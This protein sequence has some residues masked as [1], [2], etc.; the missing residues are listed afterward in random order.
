MT[1]LFAGSGSDPEFQAVKSN[2]RFA[3]VRSECE[4]LWSIFHPLADSN[5]VDQFSRDFRA[6]FWELYIGSFLKER[7]QAVKAA[8]SGS[9]APDFMVPGT[10]AIFVEATNASRGSGPDSVPRYADNDEDDNRVPVEECVLRI[11][12]RLNSK[13]LSNDAKQLGSRHPYIVAVNLPFPE[14]WVASNPPLAAQATLGVGGLLMVQES[15]DVWKSV[16]APSPLQEKRSGSTIKTTS[17]CT[18]QLEH[19]AAL[20]VASVNPFSSS[21]AD[22]AIEVLHNPRATTP[23]PRGWLGLGIEYWVE[24]GKLSRAP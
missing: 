12:S 23:L 15:S 24:G 9:A 21:Y 1:D 13:A 17:F 7:H 20:V 3:D 14:A 8:K 6:R 18:A 11:T 5:F 2:Q 19:I 4:R 10:P 16:A 22:P